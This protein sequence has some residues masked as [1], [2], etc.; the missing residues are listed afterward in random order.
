MSLLLNIDT[1]LE[2]AS[3]SLSESGNVLHSSVS[4]DPKDHAAWMHTAIGGL[5]HENS[6]TF[7]DLKAVAVSIGPG[8]Y[9]GLRAGLSAA[10]GFCFALNIPLVT[11]GTLEI[12]AHSV[13]EKA[14]GLVCPLIDARRMEVYAALYEKNGIEKMAPA[15]MIIDEKSFEQILADHAV[16]FCGSGSKKLK[17]MIPGNKNAFFS[18]TGNTADSF[19]GLAYSK[20]VKGLTA[21]IAYAEPLY[22]KEFYTT[23]KRS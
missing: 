3:V 7:N 17:S 1:A 2:T 9:T 15:A 19:A 5:V 11:V 10:K 4:E 14:S 23:A 12:L 21:D 20:F 6:Y 18:E 22:I 13:M 8:S 16:L